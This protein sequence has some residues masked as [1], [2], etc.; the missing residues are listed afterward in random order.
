MDES[1]KLY[2]QLEN[3][4]NK[5]RW[6]KDM[7]DLFDRLTLLNP[8]SFFDEDDNREKFGL[9]EKMV[10]ALL[11]TP[12]ASSFQE[13]VFSVVGRMS[14]GKRSKTVVKA[15]QRRTRLRFNLHQW[16][17]DI[18]PPTHVSKRPRVET[19]L[20]LHLRKLN[21]KGLKPVSKVIDPNTSASPATLPMAA[22]SHEIVEFNVMEEEGEDIPEFE[23]ETLEDTN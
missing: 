12:A 16:S 10:L 5:P 15:L 21:V 13:R 1:T 2:Q 7:P 17:S 6:R 8:Y 11:S 4:I 9:V 19:G 20:R 14:S 18:A 22:T 3:Y 23:E